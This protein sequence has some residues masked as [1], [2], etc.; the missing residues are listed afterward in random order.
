LGRKQAHTIVA[1]VGRTGRQKNGVLMDLKFKE[2]H[3]SGGVAEITISEEKAIENARKAHKEL[4]DDEALKHFI[5]M[6]RAYYDEGD[7]L[8]KMFR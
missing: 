8:H 1:N 2:P 6:N 7:P 5:L 4:T 3:I